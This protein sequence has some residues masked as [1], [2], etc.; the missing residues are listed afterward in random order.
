LIVPITAPTCVSRVASSG[1]AIPKSVRRAAVA[2]DQDVR[3]LDVAV[4]DPRLVHVRERLEQ[5]A[6]ECLPVDRRRRAALDRRGEGAALDKS[7]S[8]AAGSRVIPT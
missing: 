7:T 1:G 8:R 2:S 5:L 4:H 6:G 3:G